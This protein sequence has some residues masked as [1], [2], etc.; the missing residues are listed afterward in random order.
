MAPPSE[1]QNT[2]PGL[3]V[4]G[5]RHADMIAA[6]WIVAVTLNLLRGHDDPLSIFSSSG[7][8]CF[9]DVLDL[10]RVAIL[11][12]ATAFRGLI[13]HVP[14]AVKLFVELHVLRRMVVLLSV[15]RKGQAKSTNEAQ[16]IKDTHDEPPIKGRMSAINCRCGEDEGA[17]IAPLRWAWGTGEIAHGNLL[18]NPNSFEQF[19]FVEKVPARISMGCYAA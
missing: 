1:K 4:I 14:S 19:H 11:L 6:I 8:Q 16:N 7:E 9:S 3:R 5:R 18:N 12:V 2:E 17:V 10:C 13:R 15:S